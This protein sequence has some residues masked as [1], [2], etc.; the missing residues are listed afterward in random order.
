MHRK[1]IEREDDKY[2]KVYSVC[3]VIFVQKLKKD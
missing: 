3:H 2:S 1:L